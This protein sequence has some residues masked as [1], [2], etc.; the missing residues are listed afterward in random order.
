MEVSR[1]RIAV[2]GAGAVGGYFGA[3]LAASGCK[4]AFIARG[5]HLKAMR[6]DGLRIKSP[7]GDLH[8]R[9]LFAS[10]PAEAGPVD[11]VL[12]CVKS[13]STEESARKL[14]PLLQDKTVILSLQNGVD[15]PD[16]IAKLWGP[17]RTLG[18]VIYIGSRILNPGV[19]EHSAGGRI[20]MG[21]LDGAIGEST[22]AVQEIFARAEVPCVISPEIRKAMWNKLVW[23]APFCA[24]SCL[25]RA[26]TRE[27]VESESLRKLATDGMAEVIEAAKSEGFGLAPTVV[28]ETLNLSRSLGDF[29]PSMLQDLEAGKPLEYEAFNGVVLEVLRRAG[30]Q[31]PVNEV[32][33]A[34]LKF[35]DQR[36]RT[37]GVA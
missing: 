20:I 13:Y 15:N 3:K 23:N 26:T 4:V 35:L 34:T 6:R 27:I 22:K 19:I 16:K 31:A 30:K 25:A 12:L 24:I 10:D 8:I 11:L 9:A 33:Y 36:I 21:E 28:E 18:G 29:K 32:F 17:A 37:G 14:G 1:A 7:Q 2:M 5:E